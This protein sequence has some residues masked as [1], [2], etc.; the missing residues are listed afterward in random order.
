M[1]RASENCFSWII[2]NTDY[3]NVS[4]VFFC[5]LGNNGGDGLAIARML[6]EKKLN[7]TTCILNYSSKKSDDFI[8]NEKRL[9][10]IRNAKILY[11]NEGDKLPVF[12]K[13]TIVVDAL[14]G[15]GLTKPAEGFIA[16]V[17][18]HINCHSFFTI[19]VDMPSG[20]FGDCNQNVEPAIVSASVTLSLQFPKLSFF[21][22]KQGHFAGNWA[23]I[24]I[25]L[26]ETFIA[27]ELT[28]DY[29]TLL[30]DIRPTIIKRKKF[31]H[32]GI[33]GHALL[34]AGSYGKIGAAVLTSKACLRAGAG[35]L[36]VHVP[37]CGYSIMQT[38]VPEA[39]IEADINDKFITQNN[40]SEQYAAVGIGPGIDKNIETLHA[41]IQ[42][43]KACKKP[44]VIDA[45]AINLLAENEEL[46]SL[47][48]HNSIITPH[49]KEF[50]RFAGE[51]YE[52][53]YKRF[54]K[55][56]ELS[57]K[58]KIIIVLKGAYT[59]ITCPDGNAYFN[60]TGNPGMAT[61]GS[62]DVLTGVILGLLSQGYLPLDAAR[63]GVFLH[64]FAG[65]M[66]TKALSEYSLIASDIINYLPAA[67]GEILS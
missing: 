61:G 51:H 37:Q 35:L 13:E 24:P 45:D 26:H 60:S 47:I 64:G 7:V 5:G 19:S 12:S 29:F 28:T 2:K 66:A 21:F 23:I 57:A 44:M 38:S 34:M 32:K 67:Y 49:I 27:E 36:T 11:L 31:A 9:S 16:K 41:L 1:E 30:N 52:D 14:L 48:P 58:Y 6:T 55:Q 18:H 40:F 39:M 62:G 10:G 56:K 42:L 15:S 3:K 20:L 33:Y 4:F 17:I 43:L 65:D 22:P 54:E 50:E 53:D 63:T 8:I 46:K 59:C 25:G